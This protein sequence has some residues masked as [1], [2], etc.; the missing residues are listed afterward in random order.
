MRYEIIP[1]KDG[2]APQ[3]SSFDQWNSLRPEVHEALDASGRILIHC[4]GGLG[5]SGTLVS[6]IRIER[7]VGPEEAIR[8]IRNHR[9]AA[10]E[11]ASQERFILEYAPEC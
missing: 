10:I 5:R 11:T 8:L 2:D 7:G 6:T 9:N 4:R 3:I 1:I